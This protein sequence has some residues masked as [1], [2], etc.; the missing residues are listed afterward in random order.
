MGICS[1]SLDINWGLQGLFQVNGLVLKK[2]ELWLTGKGD[3]KIMHL[4]NSTMCDG[5][6]SVI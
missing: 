5:A 2:I 6:N 1:E 4:T 3:W